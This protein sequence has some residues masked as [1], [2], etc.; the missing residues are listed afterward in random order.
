M[1]AYGQRVSGGSGSCAALALFYAKAGSG[2]MNKTIL[3]DLAKCG[4]SEHCPKRETCIRNIAPAYDDYQVYAAFYVKG[5]E[6]SAYWP[7]E[8]EAA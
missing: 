1:D 4:N 2:S 7:V 8:T 3:R 6:C 5:A